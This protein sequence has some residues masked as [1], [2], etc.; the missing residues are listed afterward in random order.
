MNTIIKLTT[1][2]LIIVGLSACGKTG[3][4]EPVRST[5]LVLDTAVFYYS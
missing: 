4:L 2:A 3:D 5:N 1:L